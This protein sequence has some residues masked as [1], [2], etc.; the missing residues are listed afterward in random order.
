MFMKHHLFPR[1]ISLL[2]A[3]V[4]ALNCFGLVF[5]TGAEAGAE[6]SEDGLQGL[7]F[8]QTDATGVADERFTADETQLEDAQFG[9]ESYADDEIVRVSIVLEERSTLDAGY[10]TMGIADNADAM[11]YRKVLADQQAVVTAR[12]EKALDSTLDV[13]WNLTLAANIISVNVAYGELE[14]IRAVEGVREVILETR[15]EPCET[16]ESDLA[17]PSSA[18][19]GQMIG[20]TVAYAEGYTG[21]GTRVAI[22]DTGLDMDHETFDTAAY[23]Y[24]LSLQAEEK[25]MSLEEYMEELDLLT[26]EEIERVLP[27]LNVSDDVPVLTGDNLYKTSKV[28]FGFNYIDKTST[29]ID[30]NSNSDNA[31]GHG[32]HVAGIAAANAYISNG[33]GTFSP[34]LE[35]VNVQ[36]VAP[37]AQVLIMKVFGIA[38]GAYDSDYMAAIEDAILLGCDS[39]NL[40]LG[41]VAPGFTR[42]DV[43]AELLAALAESDTVVAIAAGNS[44][45]WATSVNNGMP[46]LL[47]SEDVSTQMISSPATHTNSLAVAS[48]ENDGTISS[49]ITAAGQNMLYSETEYG[50]DKLVTIAGEHEYVFVDTYGDFM[51]LMAISDVLAGK[52]FI[53]SRGGEIS[54]SDKAGNAVYAGGVAATI[55]YNNEPGMINMDLTDYAEGFGFTEPVVSISQ[56]DA[57]AIRAASTP[58]T[59]DAGNV[60]YYTGTLTISSKVAANLYNS[61]YY[62]MSDFS[63]WGV[64][65]SLKLK[66]EITAPGGNIYSLDGETV[67]GSAYVAMSGT[68]MATPQVAGMAALV[69]QFVKENDLGTLTGLTTRALTQSLLMSTAEPLQMSEGVWYPVLQQGAGLADVGAAVTADSYILMGEDATDSAADGKIKA[70]LGDDPD[71]NGVYTFTF[72]LNNLTAEAQQYMLSAELFTQALTSDENYTYMDQSTAALQAN[73]TWTVDGETLVPAEDVSG[74]DFNGDGVVNT[75]DVQALLDYATGTRTELSNAELADLDADGDID[76][77][78]AW[79]LLNKLNTGLVALAPNGRTEIRV[80]VELTAE[81]KAALDSSFENGAY[82]EGYIF[83]KELSTEEGVEGTCHSIPMLAF[84]GNWSDPSMF[85]QGSYIE[86][87]YGEAKPSYLGFTETNYLTLRHYGETIYS[88]FAGNPYGV[89]EE[90]PAG[91]EALNLRTTIGFQTVSLIRNTAALT[92][93]VTNQDGEYLLFVDPYTQQSSAYAYY[94]VWRGTSGNFTMYST[95]LSLG[96]EEGDVLTVSFV[97]VPEYYEVDGELTTEQFKELIESGEL[98]EGVFMSSTF[99]VDSQ[100]PEALRIMKDLDTGNLVIEAKDNNYLAAVQVQTKGGNVLATAFPEDTVAGETCRVEVDLSGVTIGE[101]CLVVVG[102]YA[103][104][105]TA[106]TVTYGGEPVDYTGKMYGY[107]TSRVF[108]TDNPK[109]LGEPRWMEIDPENVWNVDSSGSKWGGSV[110]MENMPVDITAAEYVDGWVFMAGEDGYLYAAA[111]DYRNGVIKMGRWDHVT[112]GIRD[113]AYNYADGKLYALSE[114]NTIY[115]LGLYDGVLSEVVTI[116]V[117]N[118]RTSLATHK[119]LTMLA[120]DDEGNF[121]VANYGTMYTSF[122]YTFTLD[123][124]VDGKITDLAPINNTRTGTIGYYTYYGSMAWDHDKD[125]LYIATGSTKDGN[126]LGWLMK[127]DTETGKASKSSTSTGGYNAS[128]ASRLNVTLRGLYIVPSDRGDII[129]PQNFASSVSLNRTEVEGL[130]GMNFSL[131]AEVYPWNLTDKGVT[132]TTSDASV[133]TV[134][135]EGNVSLVGLGEAAV[136]ITTNAEPKLSATCNI[137]VSELPNIQLSGLV[138]DGSGNAYWADISTDDPENWTAVAEASAD[139]MGGTFVDR[140]LYVHDGYDMYGIDADLFQSSNYGTMNE[141]LIWTDAAESPNIF[142]DAAM[143]GG[144]MVLCDYGESVA[145]VNPETG[146]AKIWYFVNQLR[147]EKLAAIAFTGSDLSDWYASK[148][149]LIPRE[150]APT[151]WYYIISETGRLYRGRLHSYQDGINNNFFLDEIGETGIDLE[152]ITDIGNGRGVSMIYDEESGYLILSAHKSG[153]TTELYAINP[154]NQ[155]YTFLGTFGEG[156]YPVTT[157]YQY[158]RVSE[159]T[160]EMET[161]SYSFYIGS[162]VELSARVLPLDYENAVTWS[163]SNTKV[164]TVDENGVVTAV[165]KGTAVITATSVATDA[166]GKHATD[167]CTVTVKDVADVK[168]VVNAQIVTDEGAKWVSIDMNTLNVETKAGATTAFEGAGYYDGKIYASD[169]DFSTYGYLYAV[170]PE[171]NYEQT[172]G[173]DFWYPDYSAVDFTGAPAMECTFEDEETSS[174]VFGNAVFVSWYGDLALLDDFESGDFSYIWLGDNGYGAVAYGGQSTFTDSYEVE[175][176]TEVFYV[177]RADGDL[178]RYDWYATE[179]G[180]YQALGKSLGNVGVIFNDNVKMTMTALNSGDT[181]GLL[182]GSISNKGA[183]LYFIDMSGDNLAAAKFGTLPGVTSIEGFY[184]DSET[185]AAKLESLDSFLAPMEADQGNLST[186]SRRERADQSNGGLSNTVVSPEAV[187]GTETD[188]GSGTNT[189][190]LTAEEGSTNGII[191]VEYDA[192]KVTLESI[193]TA[194][195]FKTIVEETGKVTFGYVN[196]EA[197]TEIAVLTF[198]VKEE[199]EV[200]VTTLE[201]NAD[202]PGTAET[203]TLG[204]PTHTYEVAETKEATC[205]EEG[206]IVY[207]CACGETYTETIPATGHTAELVNVKEATCTEAGYTGDLVCSVCGAVIEQGEA[208]PANCPSAAFT[209]I[210]LGAW[211][212]ADVDFVVESGLMR[213]VSDSSFDPNGTL[214]RAMVVT[215]L[216]RMSGSPEIT[217]DCVFTDVGDTWY[218]DA[219]IWATENGVTSGMSETVFAPD[220]AVTREQIVTF[221]FRYAELMGCDTE[222]RADFSEFPDAD[223]VSSYAADAFAW[224]VAEGIIN[225]SKENDATYLQPKGTATRAQAAAFFHRLADCM[226]G[227]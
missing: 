81:Q 122:L 79:L 125:I 36:G 34:A 156:V 54:F 84:Y 143:P 135:G 75:A 133:A 30:H 107:T 67:G 85:D 19:S 80:T 8:A 1:I 83:A 174:T 102:D 189:L 177:L 72:S 2:L 51:E 115:E 95:P 161:E 45:H 118:P 208:I 154:E 53:C 196:A 13:Q 179:P 42:N 217:G 93:M 27:E 207:L 182:V 175:Y 123:D 226:D 74:Y 61:E 193:A 120:I 57:D 225:G 15:Y 43:Y 220:Q 77:Y 26:A 202:H 94:D 22:I 200:T 153:N 73:V 218:T 150:D 145:A 126:S 163:S 188:C 216:Y 24:S 201:E 210:E 222:A 18:V 192:E 89:E 148:D 55:I 164:A 105:E 11:A 165:G 151:N 31:G 147:T 159:L 92:M 66:P 190:T 169:S 167:T 98:G 91:K 203:A 114:E 180:K 116:T 183:E 204:I 104:N 144:M 4:L 47:Y 33:D 121:Y 185:T 48:V 56:A 146:Y 9:A 6:Q 198:T 223:Q 12:I 111:Q 7:E 86:T 173:G 68:S 20:S 191:T 136:T 213:G 127:L 70:E 219:V 166:S 113:M 157:L 197:L 176:A 141:E 152:G 138:T 158:E 212:H 160:V 206:Y 97:A 5:A 124:V 76:S 194:V 62:T 139:W 211:Y 184:L 162:T 100:A 195:D 209:D 64:P 52:I 131:E 63:S 29:Y 28:A 119:V 88:Y 128:A 103:K 221:L 69:Q 99:T 132:W 65:G 140:M 110:N 171:N 142:N 172:Q 214:T 40:S 38:G 199:S 44:G 117:T 215:I 50:Q 181:Q 23:E 59:D 78:D 224:A 101:E 170:D 112:A 46:G 186:F 60:L 205:T 41:S 16:E 39:V 149:A 108:R 82:V 129:E 90:Y 35:T 96:V 227:E 130:V 134:D 25:G 37:D 58:V 49:Y 187:T 32:S 155:Y 3:L 168:A 10:S 71:R 14:A 87:L 178:E 106:Y 21:A 17:Q 109:T 137:V